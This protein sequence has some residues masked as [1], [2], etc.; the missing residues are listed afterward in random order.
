MQHA[1]QRA[2]AVAEAQCEA[3][4]PVQWRGR[5]VALFNGDAVATAA[6]SQTDAGNADSVAQATTVSLVNAPR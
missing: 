1:T 6:A 3:D 2:R 4:Q 5:C